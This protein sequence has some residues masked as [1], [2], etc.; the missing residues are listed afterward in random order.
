MEDEEIMVKI[1]EIKL[2]GNQVMRR[3]I[4]KKEKI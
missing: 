3:N 4:L 2:M 1:W